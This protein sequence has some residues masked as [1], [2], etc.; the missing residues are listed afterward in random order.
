M[1]STTLPK[2]FK[3]RGGAGSLNVSLVKNKNIAK[4]LKN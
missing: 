1:E 3:I 2:V 4:K